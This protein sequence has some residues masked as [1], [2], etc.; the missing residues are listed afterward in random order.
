MADLCEPRA[1]AASRR[2]RVQG[3]VVKGTVAPRRRRWSRRCAAR[4][5]RSL[6]FVAKSE[7][8]R[9]PVTNLFHPWRR[10]REEYRT[11]YSPKVR[12][13]SASWDIRSAGPDAGRRG[14]VDWE[15][16]NM[17]AT[18]GPEAGVQVDLRAVILCNLVRFGGGRWS[19]GSLGRSFGGRGGPSQCA[20]PSLTRQVPAEAVRCP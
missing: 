12:S 11:T 5:G 8:R 16:V 13:P 2:A 1:S 3:A 17:G 15:T 19:R 20:S 4:C 18:T 14:A 10:K 6:T 9:H 7:G